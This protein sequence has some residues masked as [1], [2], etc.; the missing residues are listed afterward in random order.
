VIQSFR[1]TSI[2]LLVDDSHDQ[3]LNIKGFV[4]GELKVGDLAHSVNEMGMVSETEKS[5]LLLADTDNNSIE[6]DLLD[7]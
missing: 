2:S 3:E 1:N 4:S 7:Q 5:E 6:F